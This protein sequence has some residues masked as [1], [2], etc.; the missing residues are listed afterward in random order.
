MIGDHFMPQDERHAGCLQRTHAHGQYGRADDDA[1][2]ADV[3]FGTKETT[4]LFK[5]FI[6]IFLTFDYFSI[7]S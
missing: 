5:G 4:L 3:M 2:S 6:D 1:G 7:V